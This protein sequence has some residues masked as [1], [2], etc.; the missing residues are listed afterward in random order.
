MSKLLENFA[1]TCYEINDLLSNLM[2]ESKIMNKI[3]VSVYLYHKIIQ[4]DNLVNIN[5]I[6]RKINYIF[7]EWRCA[8]PLKSFL[9]IFFFNSYSSLDLLHW[10]YGWFRLLLNLTTPYCTQFSILIRDQR[11]QL[12]HVTLL[13]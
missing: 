12:W 7:K 11:H 3:Q 4:F 1:K 9:R 8:A 2:E 6:N 5:E 10:V 13:L